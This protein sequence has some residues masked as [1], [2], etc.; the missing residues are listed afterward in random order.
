MQSRKQSRKKSI[1]GAPTIKKKSIWKDQA[2]WSLLL[3][4][5]PAIVGY[6]LFNYI[7]IIVSLSIPFRDYKFSKGIL[8]SAWVGL[9]NFKWMTANETVLRA[10]RNTVLYGLWFMI[11]DPLF[12]AAIALLLFEIRSRKALKVYQTAMTFPNFMSMVI[13]GYITYAV[14][15]PT[16]GA[17]KQIIELV[18]G[19]SVDVYMHSEYWPF[20]LT[21]VSKWKGVGMGS[22]M[23]YASLMG[24]DVTLYEAA[25]IDGASRWKKMIYISIPHLIPLV[26]IF[27]IMG[28]RSLISGNFDLFYIIPRNQGKLYETTDILNTYTYRALANGDYSMGATVDLMQSVVGMF[29]VLGANAIVKR[30][31]PDNAMF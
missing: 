10:L 17:L 5:L 23:Y 4:C 12:D 16:N 2:S 26:C 13:V 3:L 31:S 19:E 28:A 27:T 7:P 29:L 21:I 18:G 15:S 6:L 9:A 22:L 30:I 1:K 24:A 20:I 25:E 11:L 8:G 14:L